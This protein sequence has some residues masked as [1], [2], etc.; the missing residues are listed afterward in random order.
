MYKDDL[1]SNALSS[2]SSMLRNKETFNGTMTELELER[3]SSCEG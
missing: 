2:S 3:E 1:P